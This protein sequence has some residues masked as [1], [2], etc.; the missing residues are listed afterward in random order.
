VTSK[1]SIEVRRIGDPLFCGLK[2]NQI[3]RI[4]LINSGEIK[5]RSEF[6]SRASEL[7]KSFEVRR[8]GDPLFLWTKIGA[9]S[10][11]IIDEL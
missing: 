2:L 11:N 8:V 5:I 6:C 3:H 7:G 10:S 4:L 1:G 9:S